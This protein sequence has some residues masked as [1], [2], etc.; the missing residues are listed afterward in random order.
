VADQPPILKYFA[1]GHLPPHLQLVSQPFATLAHRMVQDLP[2]GPELSAGLRKLMEAKDCAVRAALDKPKAEP[3]A[4]IP[5]RVRLDLQVPA[6]R[7]IGEALGL[8]E[9]LGADVRL[10]DAVVLLGQARDKVGEFVD[11][12]PAT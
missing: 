4:D 6:E 5:R 12:P 8:V 2:P 11:R 7:A 9:Q 1:F 3:I 10:T